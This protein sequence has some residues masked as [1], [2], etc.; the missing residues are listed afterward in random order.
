M[1]G[2]RVKLGSEEYFV[3]HVYCSFS[4]IRRRIFFHCVV[5]T[6]LPTARPSKGRQ[7]RLGTSLTLC[8]FVCVC[9]V[10]FHF[11]AQLGAPRGLSGE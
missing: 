8:L 7:M 6:K 11:D 4:I 1:R 9:L 5:N 2:V 10:T 3:A